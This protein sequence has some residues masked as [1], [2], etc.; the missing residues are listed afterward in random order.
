MA[1]GAGEMFTDEL[2][3]AQGWSVAFKDYS[4]GEDWA[5]GR[6]QG[7]PCSMDPAHRLWLE[8]RQRPAGIFTLLLP[9]VGTERLTPDPS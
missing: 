4:E 9:C 3:H 8:Q 6:S 5:D 7:E 1:A 2:R